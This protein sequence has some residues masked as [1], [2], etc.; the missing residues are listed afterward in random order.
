MK[1]VLAEA[2]A[3]P[4]AGFFRFARDRETTYHLRE[5]AYRASLSPR[6]DAAPINVRNQIPV[7][8]SFATSAA[9]GKVK[10]KVVPRPELALAHKRPPCDSTIERLIAKPMPE[11]CGLVVKNALKI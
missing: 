5:S 10:W 11:P 8:H 1:E 2:S 7:A 9:V 6:S 3:D 4:G